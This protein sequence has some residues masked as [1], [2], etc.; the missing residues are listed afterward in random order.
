VYLSDLYV[1]MRHQNGM[2]K[3]RWFTRGWTLQELLAPD[4]IQFYDQNW[5]YLRVKQEFAS[6]ISQITGISQR[7]IVGKASLREFSTAQKDGMGFPPHH[8]PY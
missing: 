2:A 8:D 1:D 7:V 5:N 6:E 3:C 4:N